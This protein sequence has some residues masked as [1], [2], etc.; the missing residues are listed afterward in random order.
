MHLQRLVAVIRLQWFPVYIAI[1]ASLSLNQVWVELN[2]LQ[3]Q[4]NISKWK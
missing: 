4:R 3:V 2:R 1:Y